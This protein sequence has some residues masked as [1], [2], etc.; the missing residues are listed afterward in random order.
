VNEVMED[1]FSKEVRERSFV[2]IA[3][4]K[5]FVKIW[6][7]EGLLLKKKIEKLDRMARDKASYNPRRKDIKNAESDVKYWRKE[8]EN[9]DFPIIVDSEND[10][11]VR[12]WK[13]HDELIITL[14]PILEPKTVMTCSQDRFLKV[15][16][17]KG[18]LMG[19]INLCSP[20]VPK[21]WKFPYDW[22]AKRLADINKVVE[23]LSLIEEKV[24]INPNLIP[25][26]PAKK[27]KKLKIQK[28]TTNVVV[29][30]KVSASQPAPYDLEDFYED[31]YEEPPERPGHLNRKL[32][33]LDPELKKLLDDLDE[34]RKAEYEDLGPKDS[35]KKHQKPR[36][37]YEEPRKQDPKSNKLPKI[38][39]GRVKNKPSHEKIE[40]N[41]ARLLKKE[42][43]QVTDTHLH[44]KIH[45]VK[46]PIIGAAPNGLN[47]NF[48]MKKLGKAKFKKELTC[49]VRF[50]PG[51]SVRMLNRAISTQSF[52]QSSVLSPYTEDL[53]TLIKKN[54]T[55]KNLTKN[56]QVKSSENL[57]LLTRRN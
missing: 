2:Y 49:D 12:E 51:E 28:K 50:Q 10:V 4:S 26:G 27:K 53:K 32:E 1:P 25:A 20:E 39:S 47:S 36:R 57:N 54:E 22:D 7:F 41:T 3:D 6:S 19:V 11:L 18:N 45:E 33:D 24:D 42:S 46:R 23:V 31:D 29:S 37:G 9:E 8:L 5:G 43:K 38:H 52:L 34:K 56:N 48:L 44:H 14:R 17:R 35:N 30:K 55:V 16:S 40:P 15:W 21:K 13:A